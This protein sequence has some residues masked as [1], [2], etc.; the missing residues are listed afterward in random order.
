[1]IE[2]FCEASLYRSNLTFDRTIVVLLLLMVA[3]F[4]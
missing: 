3:Y 2:N 4:L 1:V